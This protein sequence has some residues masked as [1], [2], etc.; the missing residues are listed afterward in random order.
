LFHRAEPPA[1][2]FDFGI[3][4]VQQAIEIEPLAGP[5]RLAGVEIRPH[6]QLVGHHLGRVLLDHALQHRPGLLGLAEL[7]VAP[8]LGHQGREI[9]GVLLQATVQDAQRLLDPPLVAVLLRELQEDARGR[10]G[11]PAVAELGHAVGERS[12]THRKTPRAGF[13]RAVGA[14][15]VRGDS[16]V[17]AL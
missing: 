2:L 1:Q 3:A 12:V 14:D 13:G 6:Q 5:V 15:S 10:V 8:P 11:F 16:K 9:A 4:V 17:A 7:Q